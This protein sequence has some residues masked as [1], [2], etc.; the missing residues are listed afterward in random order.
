V[1]ATNAGTINNMAAASSTTP[2]PD[3]ANNNGT[4]P[5]AQA[6]TMIGPAQLTVL[7]GTPRLNPQTGLYEEPVTVANSGATTVAGIRLL[8]SGLRSGIVLRNAAGA[9]SGVPYVQY[10]APLNPGGAVD[11]VLEFFVPD[12]RPFTNTVSA[13]PILPPA[14]TPGSGGGVAVNRVFRDARDDDNPRFV[15]EFNS[16]PGRFYTIIYSDDSMRTWR[17]AT[18]AVMAWDNVTQWYDDGPPKTISKPA[19]VT[20]R[21]YR[22]IRAP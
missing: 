4:A 12:R 22:V 17:V 19:S 6:Q 15:I 16:I 3:L 14:V 1:I 7:A 8:V 18:P 10:N 20:S 11:F 2:D 5:A 13:V 9:T 21:V